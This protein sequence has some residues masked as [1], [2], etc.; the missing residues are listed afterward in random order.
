MS[1]PTASGW[2][3]KRCISLGGLKHLGGVSEEQQVPLPMQPDHPDLIFKASL[4]WEMFVMAHKNQRLLHYV[5]TIT[6]GHG[7]FQNPLIK[8]GKNSDK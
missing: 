7:A 1:S 6:Q 2:N 8:T 3:I 5:S 4:S